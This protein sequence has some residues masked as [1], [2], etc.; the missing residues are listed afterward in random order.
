MAETRVL[1]VI[2]CSV[3]DAIEAQ[4]GGASRL[5]IVRDLDQGGLTPNFEL[6]REIKNTV[7]LPLRVMVRESIGY[8]AQNEQEIETL[9]NAAQRFAALKVDGLV[10]GYLKEKEVDVALTEQIL[11]FAPNLRATFHHAFEDAANQLAALDAIKRIAQVDRI[12]SSGGSGELS[13]R[14]LRLNSYETR[15]GPELTILA[16]GGIDRVAI[17]QIRRQTNLREFHVGR[18]ARIG[19]RIEGKVSAELVEQL[20]RI[21]VE[22]QPGVNS[23][24][25]HVEEIR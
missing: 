3:D 20:A 23:P 25:T 13:Q 8:E 18:A 17:T 19:N 22:P 11:S 16:G 5:E 6:V 24:T 21:V 10:L 12:L 1:E 14:I 15:S 7:D 2:A 4:R 9:C